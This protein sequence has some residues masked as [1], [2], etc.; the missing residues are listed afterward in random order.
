MKEKSWNSKEYLGSVAPMVQGRNR[1]WW[2]V[3]ALMIVCLY[4]LSN[5]VLWVPWSHS[6]RL[7]IVMMLTVNPLFWGVGIYTCLACRNGD[8]NLMKKALNI[9][10]VAVGI[11]LISDYFFFAVCMKSKDV[12]HVTTFY[13]YAWLVVLAFGEVFLFGKRLASKQYAVTKELLLSLV[14][15][16]LLLLFLLICL[17]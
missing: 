17:I 15:C 11:S 13:G 10:L 6:P 8:E 7:G 9:S 16:L 3:T 14:G 2:T 12:W 4:W 5:V 1:L